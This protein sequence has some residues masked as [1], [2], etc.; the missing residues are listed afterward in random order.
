[1]PPADGATAST[2]PSLPA[3][4]SMKLQT[5]SASTS[6]L[7]AT[8]PLSRPKATSSTTSANMSS[9]RSKFHL[10]KS[11]TSA[12]WKPPSSPTKK[13]PLSLGNSNRTQTPGAPGPVFGTGDS[14]SPNVTPYES[15]PHR[16]HPNNNEPFSF[17]SAS[18]P[19]CQ[20]SQSHRRSPH[21]PILRARR[22]R[23]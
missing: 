7:P 6:A 5:P 18:T 8:T 3:M 12:A 4:S 16:K 9:A 19:F 23:H 11:P 22:L 14:T 21:V 15:L 1:M 17:F 13:I 10:P 20:L 2:S